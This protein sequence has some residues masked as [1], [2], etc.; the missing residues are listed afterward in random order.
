[1]EKLEGQAAVSDMSR[2]RRRSDLRTQVV[3]G[4]MIVLDRQQG[5]VHQLNKTASY[6]WEQ[7]DG[8]RTAAEVA[9]Q[10]CEN[11]EVEKPTALNDVLEV[12]KTLQDLK[13]LERV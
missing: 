7:C 4:E 12:L 11:F 5:L 1:M 13:L 10:L 2:L 3:D 6:I 8:Q 9:S